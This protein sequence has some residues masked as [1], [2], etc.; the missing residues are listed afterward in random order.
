MDSHATRTLATEPTGF[1]T[2]A[3][4]SHAG[5]DRPR[6]WLVSELLGMQVVGT[7]GEKLG[8][9]DDVVVHP[10]G[11]SSYAVL[12]IGG[13]LGMGDKLFAMPFTVFH[14]LESNA[15]AKDE[16]LSLVLPLNKEQLLAAPGFDKDAWPNLANP[17]W[18]LDVDR[19]YVGRT[20]PN[21]PARDASLVPAPFSS[22]RATELD[23]HSVKT[24]LDEK[25]GDLD[26]IA[27]D[28]RGRVRYA[29]LSVGGFLGMG[30]K[31][32]AVPWDSLSF[33]ANSGPGEARL[34]TLATTKPHLESAPQYKAGAEHVWEMRD[35]GWI[36][37]VY[38]HF[39][40]TPR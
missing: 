19:F 34:I 13:W 36:A 23:G 20:N 32:I 5:S 18:T 9:I 11:H 28:G 15:I 1:G 35:A 21:Q 29:V 33:S 30:E 12:S 2:P 22:L 31:L 3:G 25:L 40:G 7:Q 39:D 24:L 16:P 37:G 14:A 17:E 38:K 27:I 8:K 26:E 4:S 6:I 10:G